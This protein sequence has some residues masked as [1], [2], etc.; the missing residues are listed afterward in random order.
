MN[1]R[2]IQTTPPR[3][4]LPARRREDAKKTRRSL[5]TVVDLSCAV[6]V[7]LRLV[8]PRFLRLLP[9][10]LD[11]TLSLLGNGRIA[12]IPASGFRIPPASHLLHPLIELIGHLSN[13]VL[14]GGLGDQLL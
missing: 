3:R 1:S 9:V 8:K 13:V 2:P 7:N 12:V 11:E 5:H 4:S 14:S 10:F 6:Q